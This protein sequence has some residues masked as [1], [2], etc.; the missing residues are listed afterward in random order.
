MFGIKRNANKSPEEK[1]EDKM[2]EKIDRFGCFFILFMMA[3]FVLWFYISGKFRY[4]LEHKGFGWVLLYVTLYAVLVFV[5]NIVLQII[6]A[7]VL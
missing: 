5:L 7:L 3:G 6:M 4:T 1:A 2:N